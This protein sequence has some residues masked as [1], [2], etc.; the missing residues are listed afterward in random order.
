MSNEQRPATVLVVDDAPDTV[1]LLT[2]ALDAA[3]MQVMVALDGEA[4]LR[5]A[6]RL[7]PDIVLL[8]AV[9]PEL[10][11]FETCRRLKAMSG[12]D[13]VP[14]IFMT[15]LKD[16][17]DAVRGF[18]AGGADYVTKPI[19]L[20]AMLARMRVHLVNAQKLRTARQ[21]LDAADQFLVAAS[22]GGEVR[23]FTPQAYRLLET[24][25]LDKASG[26]LALPDD[27]MT[28]LG[29][30]IGAREGS[31]F[32][33]V[34][35]DDGALSLRVT[36]VRLSAEGDILFRLSSRSARDEIAVLRARFPLTKREAEVIAWLA[37]GKSN[38]D[39]ADILALSPRTVDKHLEI[40][41]AKLN[42]EN[43]TSAAALIFES[44]Q[45]RT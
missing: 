38:R 12:F 8:D 44:T 21:A 39:I 36:F 22:G 14:V 33:D 5:S 18:E 16:E 24:R 17:A 26:A 30:R 6:S 9:M 28:W 25:F 37:K 31:D 43:R 7:A 11:G 29:S 10:D 27:L 20:D 34:D 19:V 23:W 15:G 3:G 42:V 35:T 32:R 41:F 13:L 2:D 45:N 4:A 1:R 40:I